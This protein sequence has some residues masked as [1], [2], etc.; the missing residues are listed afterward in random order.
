MMPASL[1]SLDALLARQRAAFRA[2]PHPGPAVRRDRLER[3]LLLADRHE[4]AFIQA[5][6]ADFGGRSAH[7]TR[8]A[9]LLVVR[10]GIRHALRHLRRW[11]R[12]RRMPTAPYFRPGRN[13]LMPQPLGVVGIIA[14]WNYPF[15]LSIGPAVAALA[16]GNRVLVKPSELAP[17]FAA[18]LQEAVAAHFAP[19]ELAVVQGGAEFADAFARLPLDHL[20]FTGSPA[21]GRLVAR[22]AAE[23]L[24]PVTLELGG[25]SPAILAPDCD[26]ADAARRIAFGKLLNAGQTCVAPDYLLVP[27][28]RADAVAAAL[29]DAIGRLYPGLPATPDYSAILGERHYARLAGLVEDA[30]AHGARVLQPGWPERTDGAAAR[31]FPPTLVLDAPPQARLMREEIFGPILPILEYRNPQEA[32][33]RINAGERPLALY[34]FGRDP[35][36][37]DHALRSTH[38]GGVCVNDCL[39]QLAQEAQPFGGVGASGFGA[40]HGRWGFDRFSHLKPV[41]LQSRLGGAPLFHPPYG[42]TF[43]ALLALLKKIA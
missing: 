32:I 29:A 37:R 2:D 11:M 20:F 19:D 22:A 6:D 3:L 10:A 34:W 41:F 17:R 14:P 12:V 38:A 16:A 25:K 21:V 8:L 36:L 24:T 27:A 7:E 13:R 39:W 15:Q 42:R 31:K 18:A 43:E 5:I 40:Y 26:L 1:E 35:G 4:A 9:E 28:G 30:R 33:D 23:R